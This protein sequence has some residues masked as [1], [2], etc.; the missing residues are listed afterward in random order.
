MRKIL[1][2]EDETGLLWV[3][4][5]VRKLHEFG[6]DVDTA[7]GPN[8]AIAKLTVDGNAYDGILLDIL[9]PTNGRY[10][11]EETSDGGNTGLVLLREIRRGWADI[12]IVILSVKFSS[13]MQWTIDQGLVQDVIEKPANP[14]RVAE[15]LTRACDPRGHQRN[16]P[17]S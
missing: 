10:T 12:P 9:M 1:Y 14:A 13:S 4:T 6:F 2:I 7:A 15:V 3:D 11:K 5:M 17:R 16:A 8:E